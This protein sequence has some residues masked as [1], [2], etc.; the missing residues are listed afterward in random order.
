MSLE[1]RRL[2]HHREP[3]YGQARQFHTWLLTACNKSLERLRGTEL[4]VGRLC[5]RR[6][7]AN[8]KSRARR[9][10]PLRPE[11]LIELERTFR[12]VPTDG[13]IWRVVQRDKK[14]LSVANFWLSPARKRPTAGMKERMSWF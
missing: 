2:P 14:T 8:V 5:L 10:H 11:T 7:V 1:F 12:L 6:R 13:S 9:L 4:E 3:R